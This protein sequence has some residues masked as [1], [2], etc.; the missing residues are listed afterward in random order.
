MGP[1]DIEANQAVVVRRDNGEKITVSLDTIDNDIKDILAKMQVEMLE[2]ARAHREEHTYD[3]HNY[4]EFKSIVNSK[5]GFIR[6]M[7]C[8]DQACEDKIKEDT[9]ATSRC[10]P[11]NQEAIGDTCVCCGKPA[12]KLVYWGKAY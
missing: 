7:W 9:T 2:R 1:R 5:P 12:H 10:M 4:E 3:A 6:G 11:F 8:G